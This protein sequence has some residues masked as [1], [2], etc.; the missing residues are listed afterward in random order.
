MKNKIRRFGFYYL[1]GVE[2]QKKIGVVGNFENGWMV[3]DYHREGIVLQ[4]KIFDQYWLDCVR[5][6]RNH[7][8]DKNFDYYFGLDWSDCPQKYEGPYT[9]DLLLFRLSAQAPYLYKILSHYNI[10]PDKKII[11]MGANKYVDA[12]YN[13]QYM[14]KTLLLQDFYDFQ[15]L[16]EQLWANLVCKVVN[17]NWGKSVF[18]MDKGALL[19]QQEKYKPFGRVMI[20]QEFK[21]FSVGY[22]DKISWIHDIR[23]CFFWDEIAYVVMRQSHHG[24]FRCNI[25]AWWVYIPLWWDEV[26]SELLSLAHEIRIW[27]W[28]ILPSIFSLD[29]AYSHIEQK[30]YLL[31]TNH[32]PWWYRK[33]FQEYW[34]EVY[35]KMALFFINQ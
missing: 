23:I 17:G 8:N 31:E 18:L 24:D 22:N 7:Y 13:G 5:L 3:S 28:T 35:R 4:K 9:P 10:L 15:N 2:M 27:F 12:L 26:P 32:S 14:P 19:A 34:T 1:I 21:D 30:W 6:S 25:G 29:F 11:E 16:Q 20:V 33:G